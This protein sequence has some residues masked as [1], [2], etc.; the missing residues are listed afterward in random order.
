MRRTVRIMALCAACALVSM[1]AFAQNQQNHWFLNAGIGPSFGTLGSTPVADASTGYRLN[2]HFSL[3]GELG[4]LPH[5]SFDKAGALAPSVPPVVP[6]LKTY[7]NAYHTNANLFIRPSSWGRLTPYATAGFGAFTGSTVASGVVGDS[8]F[9]Q[10]H[11]ETNPATNVGVGATYRVSK[12][13]GV[14]A[15]YRHFV[16]NAAD[17]QHVNRLTTGVSLF[18]K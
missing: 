10:Y 14:T 16:V 9:T 2:D 3:A 6:S 15:D 17:T 7:V 13:L 18:V 12:W 8:H 5:A 4:V 11:R 1:P